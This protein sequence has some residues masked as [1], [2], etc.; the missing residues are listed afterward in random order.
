MKWHLY[1]ALMRSSWR[2]KKKINIVKKI[3]FHLIYH[4]QKLRNKL[5][6]DSPS[7]KF[8][9]GFVLGS[10]RKS[11]PFHGL[12]VQ[13]FVCEGSACFYEYRGKRNIIMAA[14]YT[15]SRAVTTLPRL[16]SARFGLVAQKNSWA[17]LVPFPPP[18]PPLFLSS[19][20]SHPSPFILTAY[21]ST[22]FVTQL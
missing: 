5:D 13:T 1:E 11:T 16:C 18:P 15:G 14:R 4:E 20:H 17:L 21:I 10:A 22:A 7:R 8:G 12:C 6:L 9:T 2:I 19:L 3:I